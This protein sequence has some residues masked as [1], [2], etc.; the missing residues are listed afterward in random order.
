MGEAAA[1]L[2]ACWRRA[3]WRESFLRYA[4]GARV[5]C[6]VLASVCGRERWLASREASLLLRALAQRALARASWIQS[7]EGGVALVSVLRRACARG[8]FSEQKMM[9]RFLAGS[10]RGAGERRAYAA[11]ADGARILAAA[12]IRRCIRAH[13]ASMTVAARERE[14]ARLRRQMVEDAL[15]V[16]WKVVKMR[17]ARQGFVDVVLG[18]R[19]QRTGKLISEIEEP[20]ESLFTLTL[21]D[22][23]PAHGRGY[24]LTSALECEVLGT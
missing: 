2:Q 3:S 22:Y 9:C 14:R 21:E 4:H 18:R 10:V 5:L 7:V 11:T 19:Q 24:T 20:S 1:L 15:V 12:C 23:V 6:D 8:C 13:Y 16:L 17:H